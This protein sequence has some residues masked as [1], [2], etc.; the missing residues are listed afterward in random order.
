[1]SEKPSREDLLDR[2]EKA[3][4]DYE[5]EFHGCSRCVFKALQ[6]HLDIGDETALKASTPLAAGVAMRGETCG[7]LLGG[8]LAIGIVT[9]SDDFKD[10]DAMTNAMG[11]GFRLA[12][13]VEKEL[14]STNCTELQEQELGRFYSLANPDDYDAFIKAGGY[15]KCSKVCGSIARITASYILDYKDRV[16]E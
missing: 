15:E 5:K 16:K 7:A 10:A 6:D 8:M 14:G 11:S 9:A 12:R 2:I 3:A 4:Y 1:M 13:K